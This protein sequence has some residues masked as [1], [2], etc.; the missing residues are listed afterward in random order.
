MLSARELCLSNAVELAAQTCPGCTRRCAVELLTV[1][2]PLETSRPIAAQVQSAKPRNAAQQSIPPSMTRHISASSLS[3]LQIRTRELQT[4]ADNVSAPW[5]RVLLCDF[6]VAFVRSPLIG[7]LVRD[8]QRRRDDGADFGQARH[9]SATS[10]KDV[11]QQNHRHRR[12]H[13]DREVPK[14]RLRDVAGDNRAH[15]R[16]KHRQ[17]CN[18]QEDSS[19]PR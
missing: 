6:E 17:I 16:R 12:C 19:H 18:R 4:A 13:A 10:A 7:P 9:R 8:E 5:R 1:S 15:F 2:S 11:H 14:L 3:N